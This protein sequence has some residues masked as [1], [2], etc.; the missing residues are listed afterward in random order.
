M[1]M[2]CG[3]YIGGFAIAKALRQTPKDVRTI[4]VETG[5]QNGDRLRETFALVCCNK[6]VIVA[7][8]IVI[9]KVTFKQ[10]ESDVTMVMPV[11]CLMFTSTP[12]WIW[13]CIRWARKKFG[14]LLFA[15]CYMRQH[16]GFTDKVA[17]TG[18][19]T[20]PDKLHANG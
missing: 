6:E 20:T 3:G 8:A 15:L 2:I 5:V 14:A 1:L 9:C 16:V 10:P 13:L 11:C 4:A 17:E 7:I 18:A 12:L 19:V